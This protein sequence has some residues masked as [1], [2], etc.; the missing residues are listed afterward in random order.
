MNTKSKEPETKETHTICLRI[1]KYNIRVSLNNSR[2]AK[3]L[4]DIIPIESVI[5]TWGSEIYF[6]IPLDAELEY[7]REIVDIGTVAYW[8]Y[9]RALCIFFGLTPASKT[10]KPQAISPVSVIGSLMDSKDIRY[11]GKIKDGTIVKVDNRT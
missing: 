9:G 11:L 3:K 5:K 6:S 2:T 1:N 10:D 8:P 4:M 7:G